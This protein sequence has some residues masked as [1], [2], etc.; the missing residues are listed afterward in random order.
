MNTFLKV[1]TPKKIPLMARRARQ[2]KRRM[3]DQSPDVYRSGDIHKMFKL[4]SDICKTETSFSKFRLSA[5]KKECE[6]HNLSTKGNKFVLITSLIDHYSTAH[7][8]DM[9]S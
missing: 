7:N 8:L 4:Q 1:R 3:E 6:L 5:I 2:M 9:F